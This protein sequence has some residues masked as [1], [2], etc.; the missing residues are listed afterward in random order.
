MNNSIDLPDTE[1]STLFD[2]KAMMEVAMQRHTVNRRV[3]RTRTTLQNAFIAL[4]RNKG[5]VAVTIQNNC[6]AANVRRSTF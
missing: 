2:C 1:R 5:Y 6:D 4:I 3:N